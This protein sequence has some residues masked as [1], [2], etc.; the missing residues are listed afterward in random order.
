MGKRAVLIVEE[1]H[2]RIY[3]TGNPGVAAA[4]GHQHAD[5][6]QGH[7]DGGRRVHGRSPGRAEC[8]SSPGATCRESGARGGEWFAGQ[9]QASR[10]SRA[11]TGP[12]RC[13][14]R[15][16]A[17]LRRLVRSAR[18]F[19]ALKLSQR[20]VGATHI[21][22]DIGCHSFAT[23]EAVFLRPFHPRLRHEPREPCRR[24]ADDEAARAV[25]DG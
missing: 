8:R 11:A 16:A 7:A 24:V 3:R 2:A 9:C 15:P 6:R 20:D 18:L 25:G 5:P 23:F 19:A 14:P 22:A 1:G 4:R 10:R 12:R 17:I 13:R 21:A